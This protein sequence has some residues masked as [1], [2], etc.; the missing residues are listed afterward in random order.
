MKRRVIILSVIGVLAVG[1][2]AGLVADRCLNGSSMS[3]LAYARGA[4]ESGIHLTWESLDSNI[5]RTLHRAPV[6]GGWLVAQQ[7]GLAF[8]PDPDREWKSE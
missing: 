1:F 7:E 2:I 8:V 6:P 5:T 3:S 4:K